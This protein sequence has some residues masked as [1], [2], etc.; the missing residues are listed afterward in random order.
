MFSKKGS[1]TI[2]ASIALTMF[3][4]IITIILGFSIVFRAQ[5]LISH[6]TS[7]ASQS[8]AIESYYRETISS[9]DSAKS[10]SFLL[11]R[12]SQ[13]LGNE[14]ISSADDWYSSLGNSKFGTQNNPIYYYNNTKFYDI[15]KQKFLYAISDDTTE[16]NQILIDAGIEKG[17]DGIDFSYS[18]VKD[19]VIT[20]NVKYE[21][22]LPFQF[23][24]KKS[25]PFSKSSKTKSFK[26]ID[27][28]NGYIKTT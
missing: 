2:E 17:I 5:S 8:L 4:F 3:I 1:L 11:E 25:I 21:V 7:Q 15:L 13:L 10:L 28:Q 6:A 9:S 22:K 27:G 23:F 20:V 14:N 19:S 18:S 16:A 24:G 26:K 12:F